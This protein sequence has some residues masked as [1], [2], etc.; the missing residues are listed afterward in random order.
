[1]K[2]N[3]I[4]NDIKFIKLCKNSKQ[5]IKNEKYSNKNTMKK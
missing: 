1:M 5:P 4:E 2:S 3:D